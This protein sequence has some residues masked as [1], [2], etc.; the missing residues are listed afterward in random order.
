MLGFDLMGGYIGA[1]GT[2]TTDVTGKEDDTLMDC[3]RT[4]ALICNIGCEWNVVSLDTSLRV[5]RQQTIGVVFQCY[6][7]AR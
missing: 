6:G 1:A 2:Y 3:L 4:T 7:R 5:N